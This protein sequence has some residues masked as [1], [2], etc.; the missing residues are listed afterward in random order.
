MIQV[1]KSERRKG[2]SV[3]T[4]YI[5]PAEFHT[6]DNHGR[7]VKP[8]LTVRTFHDTERKTFLTSVSRLVADGQFERRVIELRNEDPCPIGGGLYSESVARYSAKALEEIHQ[9]YVSHVE[10]LPGPLLQDL[11]AWTGRAKR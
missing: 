9:H 8:V 6:E 3:A 7:T 5:L 2:R 10:N 1:T 4:N 11:Y